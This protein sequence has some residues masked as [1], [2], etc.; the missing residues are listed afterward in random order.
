MSIFCIT[1]LAIVL[2]TLFTVTIGR[3]KKFRLQTKA[4]VRVA[5]QE[6]HLEFLQ[7]LKY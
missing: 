5:I 3:K 7:Y 6:E 1:W 2:K 4:Q